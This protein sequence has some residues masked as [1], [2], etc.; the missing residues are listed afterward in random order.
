M[1]G[2]KKRPSFAF[3]YAAEAGLIGEANLPSCGA[4]Q[5]HAP[6]PETLSTNGPE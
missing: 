4:L 6:V 2:N 5:I 1:V 3:Q